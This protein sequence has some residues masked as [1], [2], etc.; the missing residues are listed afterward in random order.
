MWKLTVGPPNFPAADGTT[1]AQ[2]WKKIPD[3]PSIFSAWPCN[4]SAERNQARKSAVS[5]TNGAF[6]R[7]MDHFLIPSEFTRLRADFG[8]QPGQ[9]IGLSATPPPRPAV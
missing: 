3:W 8:P 9:G 7:F 5:E 2:G 4:R 6:L 1:S